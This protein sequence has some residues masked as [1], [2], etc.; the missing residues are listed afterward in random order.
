MNV[1]M[2]PLWSSYECPD[3]LHHSA[4]GDMAGVSAFAGKKAGLAVPARKDLAGRIYMLRCAALPGE[5][6]PHG[7]GGALRVTL[8][9]AVFST[10]P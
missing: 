8:H 3:G 1:N 10:N 9:H 7:G 2:M 4:Q 6:S 5:D